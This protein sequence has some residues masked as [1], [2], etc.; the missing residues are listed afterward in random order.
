MG[1]KSAVRN[2]V[3]T[4]HYS[5]KTTAQRGKRTLEEVGDNEQLLARSPKESKKSVKNIVLE[6]SYPESMGG[7]HAWK[8]LGSNLVITEVSAL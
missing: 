7:F 8:K 3:G 1:S 2:P 6:R 5:R 4:I